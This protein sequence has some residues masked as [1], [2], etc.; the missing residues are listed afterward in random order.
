MQAED[1]ADV[2]SRLRLA[3]TYNREASTLLLSGEAEAAT[4]LYVKALSITDVANA[5][6]NEQ[7]LYTAADSYSGLGDVEV[8]LASQQTQANDQRSHLKKACE[9]YEASLK[10]WD[11]VREPGTMSPD[12]FDCTPPAAVAARLKKCQTK[13]VSKPASN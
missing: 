7:G 4:R 11:T 9:S 6:H 13:V 3:A 5:A 12:G 2:A 1:A 10:M 8:K